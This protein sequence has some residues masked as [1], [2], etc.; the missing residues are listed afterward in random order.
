MLNV[1][2]MEYNTTRNHLIVREY[3]RHIQKM[4]EYVKTIEDEEK[5]Q[6]NAQALIELMGFLN[7]HLKNV[8]DFRH[9][10]WDHLFVIADFDL[11]VKSPYPIPTRETLRAKPDVLGYPKRYPRYNHLGKN[12]EIV[13]DKAL[14]EE[15]P[16]KRQGFANAIAYYMKLTYSNWHKELVH[17]DNIQSE[18]QTITD[19]QL[20]FNNRPFVKHRVDN[21]PDDDYRSNSGGGYRKNFGQRN[22]NNNNGNGGGNRN[23]NGNNGNRGNN[24]NGG[25]RNN[26]NGGGNNNNNNR[27]FKKRY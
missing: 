7:P 9:K 8:E 3:G 24:N 1:E 22:N 18:L 21:R 26:N 16:E 13:I 15:N 6:R 14:E 25:N 17:D 27:N 11:D 5:R 2:N 12:I 10:L 4:V 19:G 20:E 23:N